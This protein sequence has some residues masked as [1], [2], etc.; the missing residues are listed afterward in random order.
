MTPRRGGCGWM[1]EMAPAWS[2]YDDGYLL[3]YQWATSLAAGT[4]LPQASAPLALG[5]GEVAHTT[6]AATRVAGYFGEDTGYR[7]SLF[8]I[9]GPVGLALTGAASMARNS[10]KKAAARQAAIPRWHPLG[11]ADVVMT[12][13][14]LAAS[15]GGR[16]QSLWYAECGPLQF[17][18]GPG[19]V[20]AVLVQSQRMPLLRFESPWAP[21]LYVLVHHLL[22][23]RPPAPPLPDGLLERAQSAGRMPAAAST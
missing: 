3:G 16:E 10:A 1:R 20:P 12:S 15:A 5:P 17:A 4:A 9:G 13:Q 6:L 2:A 7:P 8:L 18:T 19:G 21:V 23:G 14:R 11:T 22:D